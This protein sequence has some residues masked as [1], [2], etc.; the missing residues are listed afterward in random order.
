[1]SPSD[2]GALFKA[3]LEQATHSAEEE[4]AEQAFFR[5]RLHDHF[6]RDPSL[7]ADPDGAI[8]RTEGVSAAFIR[9][10]FRKATLLAADENSTTVDAR[11]LDAAIR[12]LVVDGGAL[13]R[14]LLGAAGA[15]PP[16]D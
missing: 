5:R 1:M 14:S 13:T 7:A 11:H 15:S 4:T 2:F 9:E 12:E 16:A 3:F 6:G 8:S 10:L